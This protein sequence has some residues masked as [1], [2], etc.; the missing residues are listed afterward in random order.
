MPLFYPSYQWCLPYRIA[1]PDDG[2]GEG[3]GWGQKSLILVSST[4][5]QLVTAAG[6]HRYS[7]EWLLKMWWIPI[8]GAF[9]FKMMVSNNNTESV[10]MWNA[11]LLTN[12]IPVLEYLYQVHY[13]PFQ[14]FWVGKPGVTK[15]YY[16][17]KETDSNRA[18]NKVCQ[19][20]WSCRE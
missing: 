3:E 16:T 2:P 14:V 15:L 18:M 19:L 10:H 17:H 9:P 13:K 11:R 20:T 7:L 8:G 5:K 1:P 4:N 6:I 12:V